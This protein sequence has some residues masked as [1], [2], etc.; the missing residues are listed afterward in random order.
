MQSV[1]PKVPE[2]KKNGSPSDEELWLAFTNGDDSAYTLLYFRFADRIYSYLRL[3]VGKGH[4][5]HSIEDVFQDLWIRV[6]HSKERFTIGEKGSFSGWLFRVAHNAAISAL[7]RPH[8]IS[9]FNEFTDNK[10]L[11]NY[12][13]TST[14]QILS[15]DRSA[16]EAM[17]LLREI[18]ENLPIGFREVYLL[19]EYED[20]NLDQLSEALGLTKANA[21]VRLFRA[22]K[23][24]RQ[25]MVEKL[26]IDKV[27]FKRES[28]T[29]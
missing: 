23:L 6:F 28:D 15:D 27:F 18:V 22:R 26:G 8:P 20:F 13:T 16:E 4:E 25:R 14:G 3:Y 7:R 17:S 29:E 11:D 12:S 10:F 21:K 5:R 2:L 1:V 19:S 24:V 9:S